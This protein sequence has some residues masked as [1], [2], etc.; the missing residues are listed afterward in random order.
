M[1]I[2]L[3]ILN[4]RY[5]RTPAGADTGFSQRGGG[6]IRPKRGKIWNLVKMSFCPPLKKRYGEQVQI[7]F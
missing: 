4:K 6:R 2:H 7:F 5:R 1:G 3:G